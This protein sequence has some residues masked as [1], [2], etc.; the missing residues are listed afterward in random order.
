MFGVEKFLDE[1]FN[2]FVNKT[3]EAMKTGLKRSNFA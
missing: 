3:A 1:K 2:K